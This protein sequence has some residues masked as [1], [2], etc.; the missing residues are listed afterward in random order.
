MNYPK[1]LLFLALSIGLS[2]LGLQIADF[3]TDPDSMVGPIINLLAYSWGPGLAAI[4]IQKYVFRGSL[5]KFGWNRKRYSFNWILATVFLP[6][7]VVLSTTAMV[8]IL[9]NVL[10]VPGFGEVVMGANRIQEEILS[11]IAPYSG[12]LFFHIYMPSEMWVLF[13]VILIGGVFLGA[14]FNLFFNIGEELGFRGFLLLETQKLGFLGGNL[15]VGAAYGLWF[16]PYLWFMTPGAS[17]DFDMIITTMSVVGYAVSIAFPMAYF[18]LKTRSIYASATFTGIMNNISILSLFFVIG[19]DPMVVGAQG[20]AGMFVFLAITYLII[21][22][23][24]KFV[25]TYPDLFY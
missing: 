22:Y 16:L 7:G 12:D 8:F 15:I 1:I 10:N 18:A 19:G 5:A 11:M 6:I 13:F 24:S 3:F 4:L 14:T 21:R 20:L 25:D 17:L 23:D 9:G 2:W